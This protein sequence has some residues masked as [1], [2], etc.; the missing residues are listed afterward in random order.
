MLHSVVI[1]NMNYSHELNSSVE[2][3]LTQTTY[4]VLPIFVVNWI[5]VEIPEA[6]SLETTNT[7]MAGNIEAGEGLGDWEV[8]D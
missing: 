2:V 4:G 8:N 7:G 3:D 6:V 1:T 5:L